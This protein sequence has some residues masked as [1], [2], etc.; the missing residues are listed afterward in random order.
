MIILVAVLALGTFV[1]T[2]TAM[3][4]PSWAKVLAGFWSDDQISDSDFIE[5]VQYLVDENVIHVNPTIIEVQAETTPTDTGTLWKSIGALQDEDDQLRWEIYNNM[6]GAEQYDEYG[7]MIGAHELRIIELEAEIHD[8]KLQLNCVIESH[9]E[10][11]CTKGGMTA[12][13]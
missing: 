12:P 4:N 1:A 13:R 3:S 5:A 7:N 8:M 9:G 10:A 6:I 2:A 11:D